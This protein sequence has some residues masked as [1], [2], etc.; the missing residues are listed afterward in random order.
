MLGTALHLFLS[1]ASKNMGKENVWRVYRGTKRKGRSLSHHQSSCCETYSQGW[2]A[3]T[4]GFDSKCL[5]VGNEG[6]NQKIYLLIALPL[7]DGHYPD[8]LLAVVARTYTVRDEP[9]VVPDRP[10]AG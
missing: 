8:I 3:H 5:G 7:L 2:S 9:L 6:M 1:A 10:T 4:G